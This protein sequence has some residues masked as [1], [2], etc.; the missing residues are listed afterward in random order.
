M[1]ATN[2]MTSGTTATVA[3]AT[4]DGYEANALRAFACTLLKA[5]VLTLSVRIKTCG[6]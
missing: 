6:L 1:T 3:S 4:Q 2:D 5:A